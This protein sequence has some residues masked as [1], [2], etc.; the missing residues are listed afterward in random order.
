[1]QLLERA[2]LSVFGNQRAQLLQEWSP[3]ETG[4]IQPYNSLSWVQD[5]LSLSG[6]SNVNK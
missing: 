2:Q 6:F 1:M 4:D 5:T 3:M